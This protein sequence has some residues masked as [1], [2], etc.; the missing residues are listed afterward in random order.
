[1]KKREIRDF[2]MSLMLEL[3]SNG[4]TVLVSESKKSKSIYL[5]CLHVPKRIRISDHGFKYDA[6]NFTP[7]HAGGER[8]NNG[9]IFFPMSP[10]G[11]NGLLETI[12]NEN[13]LVQFEKK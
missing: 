1:M 12:K 3:T 6:Y 5:T 8:I 11:I 10:E 13:P 9:K 4:Y 7:R 2:A